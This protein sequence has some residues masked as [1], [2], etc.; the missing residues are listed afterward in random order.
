[1]FYDQAIYNIRCEWGAAG[2]AGLAP[3][4]DVVIIVDV[5]SFST[6]IDVAVGRGAEVYPFASGGEALDD[7]A[8]QIGAIVASHNRGDT[9]RYT[10]SPASL[11]PI[12]PGTRLVLPSPN[13]STLS[14]ATGGKVTFA[15]CLRNARAVAHAALSHGSSIL[16]VP[17]GER[18]R[19]GTLRPAIE[20]LIGAGA[21]ISY[22]S[23]HYPASAEA[24]V[25]LNAFESSRDQLHQTLTNCSSGRELVER[26]FPQDVALAADLNCSD[27]APHL[28]A[29]AYRRG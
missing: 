25:A 5:L 24:L 17:A 19:D 15:G 23:Q 1:M 13:G 9:G 28:S 10:L 20:D 29:G 21:I 6:C 14:L 11:A 12:P 2:I 8:T 26:G 3:L 18:W 22:L 27:C 7:Y 16:V 4:A